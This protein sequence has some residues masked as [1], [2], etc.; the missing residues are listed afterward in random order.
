MRKLGH[1]TVA[2]IIT[3]NRSTRVNLFITQVTESEKAKGRNKGVIAGMM[4][5][6]GLYEAAD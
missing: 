5:Y 2:N 6:L 4:T 3:Y 1:E